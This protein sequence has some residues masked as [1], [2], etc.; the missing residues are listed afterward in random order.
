MKKVI[1]LFALLALLSVGAFADGPTLGFVLIPEQG[2][3]LGMTLGYDLGNVG[4]ELMK[5][6]FSNFT[7]DYSFGV[8]YT[9]Q[10]DSFGYRA[11]GRVL[12]EWQKSDW[13]IVYKGFGIVLGL[14]KDWGP[15]RF[16]AEIDFNSSSYLRVVP[17]LGVEILF[18]NLVGKSIP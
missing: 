18:D 13:S 8:L 17:M 14:S 4:L 3:S 12:I 1:V 11:G 15:A 9:P 2:T 7:G 6:N 10:T 5:A 16:F